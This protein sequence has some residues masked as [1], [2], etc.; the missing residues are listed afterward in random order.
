MTRLLPAGLLL[1]A[2]ATAH[3][4]PPQAPEEQLRG[5]W[6]VVKAARDEVPNS[7]LL[8]ARYRFDGKRMISTPADKSLPPRSAAYRVLPPTD[9][10]GPARLAFTPEEGPKRGEEL[11]GIFRFQDG[12][13]ELCHAGASKKA[14]GQVPTEFVTK[15]STGVVLLTLRRVPPARAD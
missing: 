8:G 3:A 10:G 4:Q 1:A 12:Q 7:L 2:A 9:K 6:V 13:L 15:K 14:G 5:E 11:E